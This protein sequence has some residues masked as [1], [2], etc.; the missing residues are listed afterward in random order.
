ML[1]FVYTSRLSAPFLY[2]HHSILSRMAWICH[3]TIAG[4]QARGIRFNMRPRTRPRWHREEGN[5]TIGGPRDPPHEPNDAYKG[6]RSQGQGVTIWG[7]RESHGGIGGQYVGHWR[8]R[9]RDSGFEGRPRAAFTPEKQEHDGR[10]DVLRRTFKRSCSR[11]R[12]RSSSSNSSSSSRPDSQNSGR[13]G[14]PD[15]CATLSL[16]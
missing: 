8:S 4:I 14:D 1:H 15:R 3:G 13:H 12:S 2:P 10:K 9:G 6:R 7:T 5:R 16:L 11:S